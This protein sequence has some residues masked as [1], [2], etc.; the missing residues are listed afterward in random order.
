MS[1]E[2]QETT[3]VP[4]RASLDSVGATARSRV[5]ANI[6]TVRSARGMTQSELARAIG[7]SPTAVSYWE[8]GSRCPGIADLAVLATVL[9]CTIADLAD[10]PDTA[11]PGEGHRLHEIGALRSRAEALV[12]EVDQT[13]REIN[14]LARICDRM[15]AENTALRAELEQ[16]KAVEQ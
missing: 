3:V 6:R 10:D 13:W 16:R 4:P 7:R 9:G 5:A 2:T 14:A 8:S 12:A 1:G 15:H 11:S